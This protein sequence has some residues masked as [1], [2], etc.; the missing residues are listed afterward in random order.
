MKSASIA[1]NTFEKEDKPTS[2]SLL[3]SLKNRFSSLSAITKI[4]LSIFA[5]WTL[6]LPIATA[7]DF[8]I[9]VSAGPLSL[10]SMWPQILTFALPLAYVLLALLGKNLV[11]EELDKD[12]FERASFD[13]DENLQQQ[14]LRFDYL[15]CAGKIA[16]IS[17]M[18]VYA[19]AISLSAA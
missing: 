7:T 5:A 18:L 8:Y 2:I 4:E 1:N 9:D 10:T 12:R 19:I 3:E 17:T 13:S 11:Q 15:L 14:S 16:G 6:L